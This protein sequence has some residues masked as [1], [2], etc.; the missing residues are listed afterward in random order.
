[1]KKN[2][3]FFSLF[4]FQVR[5]LKYFNKFTYNLMCFFFLK[6]WNR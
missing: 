2:C 5:Y 3:E 1:M 4:L 6:V